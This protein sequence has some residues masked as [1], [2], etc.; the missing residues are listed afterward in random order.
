MRHLCVQL[1]VYK[2]AIPED[3]V[4]CYQYTPAETFNHSL[5]SDIRQLLRCTNDQA[6]AWPARVTW[7]MRIVV[8]STTIAALVL[9]SLNSTTAHLASILRDRVRAELFA[10]ANG[11]ADNTFTQLMDEVIEYAIL[12]AV[13][14]ALFATVGLSLVARPSWL[15]EHER[16][17]VY[18]MCIQVSMGLLLTIT[19]GCL[20]GRVHGYNALFERFG[21]D[22]TV[23][24]YEIMYY[25]GIGQA[26]Y[27]S[28]AMVFPF[29]ALF[30]F[31]VE[32][33]NLTERSFS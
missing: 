9:A 5:Q 3:F 28:L 12:A 29:I 26:I 25:G 32:T 18:Y 15:R 24:Y 14:S 16:P 13:V 33:H 22:D 4:T 27:G 7:G 17:W 8:V 30:M 23:P 2:E 1:E 10:S 31:G 6:M 21:Q 20:A 11:I 19:E